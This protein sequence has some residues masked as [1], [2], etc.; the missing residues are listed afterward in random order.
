M[1]VTALSNLLNKEM[2]DG[3]S[4][5]QLQLALFALTANRCLPVENEGPRTP[6]NRK[7]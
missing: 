3:H 4:V 2:A 5:T 1:L 7:T 6:T